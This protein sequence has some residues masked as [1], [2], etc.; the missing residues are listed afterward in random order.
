VKGHTIKYRIIIKQNDPSLNGNGIKAI[1]GGLTPTASG[2]VS[3][4][5]EW[6]EYADVDISDVYAKLLT[7][8][9]QAATINKLGK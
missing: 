4:G 7:T 3:I 5:G 6:H 8:Q 1:I 9:W 2:M